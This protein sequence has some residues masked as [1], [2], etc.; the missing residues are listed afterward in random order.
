MSSW[1]L[2]AS[3]NEDDAVWRLHPERQRLVASDTAS[4]LV[5]GTGSHDAEVLKRLRTF[6]DTEGLDTLAELWSHAEAGSLPRALWRLFQVRERVVHCP[7]DVG[8][9][10]QRG[11]ESLDTIDPI[12]LGTQQPVT[13]QSVRELIEQILSGSFAGSLADALERAASL[14]RLVAAGLLALGPHDAEDHG[15]T[16]SSLAWSDVAGELALSAKRER[17]GILR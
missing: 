13:A 8:H 15:V 11:L 10:V 1:R 6:V 16:L 12:V 3:E 9:L 5:R 2:E 7:D 14:A 17:N 4:L